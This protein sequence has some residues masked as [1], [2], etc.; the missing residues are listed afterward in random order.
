[1][2]AFTGAEKKLEQEGTGDGN[3]STA[4]KGK[5]ESKGLKILE[6]GGKQRE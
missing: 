4:R 6:R 3:R 1:M 2:S 5:G